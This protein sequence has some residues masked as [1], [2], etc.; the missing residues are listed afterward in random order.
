MFKLQIP[1]I[2]TTSPTELRINETPTEEQSMELSNLTAEI[3]SFVKISDTETVTPVAKEE[4]VI[5]DVP[6]VII[7]VIEP[8]IEIKVEVQEEV[9]QP[10]VA[11]SEVDHPIVVKI[12]ETLEPSVAHATIETLVLEESDGDDLEPIKTID[13]N[14][15]IKTDNYEFQIRYVPLKEGT[16]ENDLNGSNSSIPSNSNGR[17][18]SVKDIIAS[19]NKSQSLL[20]IN[21][22]KENSSTSISNSSSVDRIAASSE[23]LQKNIKELKENE[24]KIQSFLQEMEKKVDE[25]RNSY[26]DNI[27]STVLSYESEELNNNKKSDA[28]IVFEKCV[29]RKKNDDENIDW[30]PLPKPRRSQRFSTDDNDIVG[31]LSVKK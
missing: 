19:I 25:N 20:K 22:P 4:K 2:I 11:T 13:E 14:K 26:Y 27:P 16:P 31:F 21:E 30:N 15:T 7:E 23:S 28:D 10:V 5:V 9:P 6:P 29:L 3:E 17:R 12:T 18:R 8:P 24:N 1:K